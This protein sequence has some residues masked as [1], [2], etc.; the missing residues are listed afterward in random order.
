LI[1]MGSHG[2]RAFARLLLGSVTQKMLLASPCPVLV[3]REGAAPFAAWAEGKRRLRI[4]AGIDRGSTGA[5]VVNW[6]K[7]LHATG[8]TELT[9]LHEYWPAREQTRLGISGSG[10]EASGTA[11]GPK[12]AGDGDVAG[13]IERE[14]REELAREGIS[15]DFQLRVCPVQGPVSEQLGIDAQ[16]EA[17][18]LLVITNPHGSHGRSPPSAWGSIAAA[19]MSAVRVPLLVLPVSRTGVV[20]PKSPD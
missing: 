17:A 3:M 11:P 14:L 19:T 6:L 1:I 7:P 5:V 12:P 16:T 10:I 9:L 2:R 18:D 20:D 8:D 15:G 4:T 13:I